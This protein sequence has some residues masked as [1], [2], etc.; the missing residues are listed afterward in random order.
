MKAE[1][2][3]ATKALLRGR[4]EIID[5]KAVVGDKPLADF[6]TEWSGTDGKA[7]V[8]AVDNSGAGANGGKSQGGGSQIDVSKLSPTEQ[9]KAGRAAQANQKQ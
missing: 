6:M 5:N 2:L 8:K 9:M 7:F 4:V 3:D 1:F